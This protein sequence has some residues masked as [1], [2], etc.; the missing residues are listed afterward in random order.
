MDLKFIV[1]IFILNYFVVPNA[2]NSVCRAFTDGHEVQSLQMTS[3]PPNRI[4]VNVMFKFNGQDIRL[5][6]HHIIPYNRLRD[7][8][9]AVIRN[10]TH[11]LH[12]AD[13]L[14]VLVNNAR[15]FY[16]P[17]A[18]IS[19]N[20]AQGVVDGIRSRR[21]LYNTQLTPDDRNGVAAL[22]VL[23]AWMP[24]NIF[25]G[26]GVQSRADDPG[27]N[28]ERNAGVVIG[29]ENMQRLET[30]NNYMIHIHDGDM[31]N[32][33]DNFFRN[34]IELLRQIPNELYLTTEAHWQSASNQSYRLSWNAAA[35]A[36]TII[37]TK[38]NMR[39]MRRDERSTD[40]IADKALLTSIMKEYA[41]KYDPLCLVSEM[42][43]DIMARWNLPKLNLVIVESAF[44]RVKNNNRF[45]ATHKS[46]WKQWFHDT[47]WNH[48]INSHVYNIFIN[49]ILIKGPF[50]MKFD[51]GS[52]AVGFN[53]T[54]I[55]SAKEKATGQTYDNWIIHGSWSE[56]TDYEGVIFFDKN[57][58]PTAIAITE[59]ITGNFGSGWSYIYNDGKWEYESKDD[60]DVRRFPTST[61]SV[62]N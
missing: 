26:V 34:A 14:Q 32:D 17:D 41:F 7:F 4:E 20:R 6:R 56:T 37:V 27:S 43:M 29:P 62:F 9:N 18:V 50:G 21:L 46:S 61:E 24:G 28:F 36:S 23:F 11:L 38:Y 58:R 33:N 52:F 8:W 45:R 22:Q 54:D 10:P 55:N 42:N 44:R 47:S 49:H 35:S 25:V 15:I 13:V 5:S 51:D 16:D 19:L 40:D 60:W 39:N 57:G 48:L 30:L 1:F 59:A 2:S 12:F 31:V 53:S 3:R